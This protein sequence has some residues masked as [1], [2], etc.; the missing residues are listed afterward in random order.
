MVSENP[1]SAQRIRPGAIPFVFPA[2]QD[3]EA[4]VERFQQTG[5]RGEIIGPHGSGKSTLLA[6]LAAAIE[7]TGMKTVLVELHDRQRQLPLDLRSF[8]RDSPIFADHRC[9]TV[10]AKIGTVPPPAVLIV[11]GYEQ[12]SL[13][14]R[15]TLKRFC[16]HKGLGL[17]VTA[18]DSV[19]FPTLCQ[20]AVTAEL[21]EQVVEKLLGDQKS[22]FAPG[23]ISQCLTQHGGDM[24]EMLFALYDLYEQRCPTSSE[25]MT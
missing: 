16:R 11:D 9:A 10:P 14:N 8:Q 12:L 4:L 22:P 19:G 24:R 5:R 20:T 21:F 23:E 3:A 18:H 25:N 6:V 7:R 17:L 15:W 2:G 13:W 1:F